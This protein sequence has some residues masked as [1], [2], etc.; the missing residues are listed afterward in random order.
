MTN[1]NNISDTLYS[2]MSYNIDDFDFDFELF[3]FEPSN[4]NELDHLKTPSPSP[5]PPL[6]TKKRK[7]STSTSLPITLGRN[8]TGENDRSPNDLLEHYIPDVDLQYINTQEVVPVKKRAHTRRIV[9]PPVESSS[10]IST[11]LKT[12]SPKQARALR[13]QNIMSRTPSIAK[14]I[15]ARTQRIVAPPVESSSTISTT[16]KTISPKQ[17]RA[18]RKQNIMSRT[19]SIAKRITARTQRIVDPPVES[20]S[21]TLKTISPKQA[22]ALRK[23]NIMSRTP[24]IAKR[25]T[26]R[27][28]RIVDRSQLQ[29]TPILAPTINPTF[30]SSLPTTTNTTNTTTSRK[31]DIE[32]AIQSAVKQPILFRNIVPLSNYIAIPN[33]AV[34]ALEYTLENTSSKDR[35]S[36][37]FLLLSSVNAHREQLYYMYLVGLYM[38]T[39]WNRF[40]CFCYYYMLLYT[41]KSY[42]LYEDSKDMYKSLMRI[43]HPENN[44]FQNAF[45]P[46]SVKLACMTNGNQHLLMSYSP[47]AITLYTYLSMTDANT[48]ETELPLLLFQ[49]YFV[50][51]CLSTEY[52]HGNLDPTNILLVPFPNNQVVRFS[53][54]NPDGKHPGMVEFLCK[55]TVKIVAQNTSFFKC[56]E[57]STHTADQTLSRWECSTM[58]PKLMRASDSIDYS[59]LYRI[60]QALS[61]L[62]KKPSYFLTRWL[63]FDTSKTPSTHS[64]FLYIRTYLLNTQNQA[65][66][67]SFYKEHTVSGTLKV[68]DQKNMNFVPNS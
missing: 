60:Y 8:A 7:L 58:R 59:L 27:T 6:N 13:K 35:S 17:A 56:A 36:A 49:I 4:N 42:L 9:D 25:I 24:S 18:L 16:L 21:S 52:T 28:Q 62:N 12:I 2:Q 38:N 20:I 33:T 46:V 26:A 64:V 55:Y 23:Q 44:S 30:V 66:V 10:S 39:L 47:G 41:P 11:T 51:S 50:L 31:T 34:H 54:S 48:L 3:D 65:L 63:L 43:S 32:I 1:T 40:P 45:S 37:S 14:R 67:N 68:F 53:Y 61:S 22:R 19:P 57:A 29:S 5:P 15:T